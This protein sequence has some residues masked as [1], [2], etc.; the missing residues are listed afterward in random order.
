[1]TSTL[2]GAGHV[3]RYVVGSVNLTEFFVTVV[4]SATFIVTLGLGDLAPVIP[5]VIGGLISA[6][7]AG[8]LVKIA[9]HRLLMVMVGSLILLLSARTFLK[10]A[11]LL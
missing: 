3:P 9:S 2:V 7:F 8:Y 4:T 6:P 5:L 10:M 11:E 1:M